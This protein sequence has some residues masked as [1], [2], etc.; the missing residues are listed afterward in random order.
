MYILSSTLIE[1]NTFDLNLSVHA[2]VKKISMP[3]FVDTG[4]HHARIS[5]GTIHTQ[6]SNLRKARVQWRSSCGSNVLTLARGNSE[7]IHSVKKPRPE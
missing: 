4:V 5:T 6:K 2:K 3:F 7:T 1:S